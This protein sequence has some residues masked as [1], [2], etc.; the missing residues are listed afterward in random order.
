MKN[1]LIIVT[2]TLLLSACADLTHRSAAASNGP[3]ATA[4]EEK[5][6]AAQNETAA[7]DPDDNPDPARSDS[8]L[9]SVEL[10][11][12]LLFKI[13]KSEIAYQRGEWQDAYI[14]LL[15]V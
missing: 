1:A 2:L 13:L 15:A 8:P 10:T 14:T 5:E 3:I 7:I 12:D 6:D 4:A 9:P 11:D